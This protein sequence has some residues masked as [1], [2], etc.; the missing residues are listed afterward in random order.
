MTCRYLGMYL[1]FKMKARNNNKHTVWLTNT[2]KQHCITTNCKLSNVNSKFAFMQLSALTAIS[3]IDGRYRSQLASLAPYFSE[4]GLI[5]Y[6]VLV[7]VEYF[8]FLSQKKIFTM[9]A[10]VTPAKL[11][12][13]Y[14]EFTEEDA[15]QIKA[16]E[17]VT[18][19]DVK[20]V[21]YFLK[22]KLKALGAEAVLEWVHFGLTSQDI[23]NTA[24]PL[25][26]KEAIENEY[27]PAL[28]NMVLS[29]RKM[30]E[31]W[32]GIPLL[33]RTH[34]Q[35]ASPTTL[36][37]EWMVFVERLE[38]QILLL[39]HVPNA[40]KFGGATGNFNA[41]H[42]A[43]PDVD[44]Q[45]FGNEFVNNK[46]GLERMQYTTQIEHYDNL[47]AQFDALKRINNILIDF[48]RDVWT[49]ISME[50]FKQ[51]TKAGEVGS[52]AMPHK[53]NPIDFENAEGNLGIANAI[54]EYLSAKLPISRLQRDLTDSTVLRNVGVPLSHSYLALRSLEKGIG[55]LLLNKDKLKLDLENNWAV[56]AEA[57]QTILRR[58]N[59]PQPYEALKDLTRGKTSITKEDIHTFIAG[60]KVSAAVKKE[61]RAITP[62]NYTGVFK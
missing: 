10:G 22:E 18:N 48:A 3:P 2:A 30:A 51:K 45:K 33:A 17:R 56:V 44:W 24:I 29:L 61:L 34:G 41:H 49:Y 9:P 50:Y 12:K 21:E 20:A 13:I 27:L 25:S 35:P 38:G 59:Y 39:S 54:Y 4:F 23:N 15:M 43:F 7:E 42:V 60:L 55:K 37:K 1:N 32:G 57:I 52:S 40:A 47:A 8:L 31:E 58:E 26:W 14:T 46:L 6:R 11:R 19:H 36:G 53:V 62:H 16:T 5:R 28:Q